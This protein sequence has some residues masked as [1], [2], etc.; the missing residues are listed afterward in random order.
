M[1]LGIGGTSI[2]KIYLLPAPCPELIVA[3]SLVVDQ[4]PCEARL[5][6][7]PDRAVRDA[8]SPCSIGIVG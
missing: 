2:F 3:F 6:W 7:V 4:E 8:G 1:G 5:T